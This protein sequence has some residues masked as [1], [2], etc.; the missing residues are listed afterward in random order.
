MSLENSAVIFAKEV[1]LRWD[2]TGPCDE[3]GKQK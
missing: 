2:L 3:P 1:R